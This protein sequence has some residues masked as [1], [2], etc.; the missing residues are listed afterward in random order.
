[1]TGAANRRHFVER[2]EAEWRRFARY[3]HPLS[4]LALDIDLFK[5]VNDEFG[6]DIGDEVIREVARVCSTSIRDC[7]LFGRMGGEEFAVL[8]PHADIEQAR[9]VAERIRRRVEQISIHAGDLA[10]RTTVSIG[11]AQADAGMSQV[12]I[13]L[14]RADEALYA[15]KRNGRNC[16][17]QAVADVGI[18]PAGGSNAPVAVAAR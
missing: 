10:V 17:I 13:L 2:A 7:D 15:A 6:H 8:M 5:A 16:V 1:M 4:V 14:K 11:I 18:D 12:G 9:L 3:G